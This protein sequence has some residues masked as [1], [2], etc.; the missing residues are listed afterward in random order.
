MTHVV[1]SLQ[2]EVI[3]PDEEMSFNLR[4]NFAETFHVEIAETI[5]A[6]CLAHINENEDLK[7]EKLELDLGTFSRHSFGTEFKKVVTLKFEA[8]LA[9]RLSEIISAKRKVSRQ[10][11]NAEILMFFLLS[12]TLPWWANETA[13]NLNE[14]CS[15]VFANQGNTFRYFFYQNQVKENVWQRILWQLNDRSKKRIINLSP[16]LVK[17]R[18]IFVNWVAA[19]SDKI[20]EIKNVGQYSEFAS[21]NDIQVVDDTLIHNT[22]IKNAV[23]IFANIDNIEILAQIFKTY[24]DAVFKENKLFAE[25][26][27]NEFTNISTTNNVE[28]VSGTHL[29]QEDINTEKGEINAIDEL[30]ATLKYSIEEPTEK[31]SVK[32]AGIVL[33]APF[34]KAFFDELNLLEDGK[35]KNIACAF[36]GVHL[37]KFL[38]SSDQ[39]IPE[40][41]LVI[42]KILCGLPVDMPVPL[43]I[44][45]DGKEIEE[46]ESLLNA[47]ISHW[48][49]LKNTSIDG[50]REAFFKRDGLITKKDDSWLLQVERKTLDVLLDNIPWGYSTISLIWNDYL[51]S[52]EW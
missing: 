24:I 13:V 39:Q 5:E 47:V 33:L 32:Y 14:I 29:T 4:Q 36:K 42:E 35:W 30:E 49:V 18:R 31:Y 37:L 21:I 52:V 6:V 25:L 50:L 20:N 40:Y 11:S 10:L 12:G 22:L 3:C 27:I 44:V 15:D 8:A 28:P 43:T 7:I 17:T 38:S 9:K 34:L 19:L 45:L 26:V 2:F 46:A 48:N 23:A 51:L 41:S 16:E 1:N